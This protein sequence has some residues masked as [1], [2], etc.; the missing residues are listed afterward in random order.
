MAKFA[1]LSVGKLKTD[2]YK[3][4]LDDYAG[5]IRRYLDFESIETKEERLAKNASEAEMLTAKQKEGERLL[6][7]TAKYD[8]FYCL[9]AKGKRMTSEAFSKLLSQ[10][11]AGGINRTAFIIGGSNG[12]SDD[13]K[14]RARGVIS[15]SDMIFPHHLFRVMLAEQIYRA[16]TI[17]NHEKYHK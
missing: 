6:G 17:I 2:Y 13:I 10:D 11:M 16:L 3:A 14:K 7:E 12:L 1:I 5:R 9:D 8:A 4:A 15:F